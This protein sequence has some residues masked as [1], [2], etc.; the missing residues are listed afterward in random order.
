MPSKNREEKV[1]SWR[2]HIAR[3]ARFAGSQQ[4]Y[5]DAEGISVQSL[6]YWRKKLL[7][8][9]G[10]RKTAKNLPLSPFIAVEVERVTPDPVSTLPDPR[11]VAELIIHLQQAV[12]R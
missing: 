12:R 10:L 4:S 11:W 6:H 2:E 8:G 3:A 1:Q 7:G 5:C 9:G